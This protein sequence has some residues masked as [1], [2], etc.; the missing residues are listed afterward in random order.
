MSVRA[1]SLRWFAALAV[2]LG[3]AACPK[4]QEPLEVP[5]GQAGFL[6]ALTH[7]AD[8]PDHIAD[9]IR[10]RLEAFDFTPEV[11]LREQRR[12]LVRVAV[13]SDEEAARAERLLLHPPEIA[14]TAVDP[15]QAFFASLAGK[16]PADGSV[17]V[18]T[19]RFGDFK[20][21]K[22]SEI[23]YLMAERCELL[24]SFTNGLTLPAGRRLVLME[25]ERGALAF[26]VVDPPAVANPRL[27]N[28]RLMMEPPSG[29]QAVSAEMDPSSRSAFSKLYKSH[30]HRPLAILI[31][32]QLRA[33]PAVLKPKPSRGEIRIAPSPLASPAEV[34]AQSVKLANALKNLVLI[35]RLRLVEKRV[36]LAA[37]K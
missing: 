1:P 6:L 32:G 17:Q 26:L 9:R 27:S 36:H 20:H 24:M 31:D 28:V 23:G 14:I 7:D 33:L 19:D 35:G 12:L 5:A 30:L 29:I 21:G 13:G 11:E 3:A 34:H 8:E 4:E 15:G 22:V 18:G 16:L 10:K 2:A 37:A 25:G